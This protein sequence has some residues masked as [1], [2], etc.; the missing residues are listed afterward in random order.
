MVN[1]V[2][3]LDCRINADT[4]T[5]MFFSWTGPFSELEG[6][7][8]AY[9]D[10]EQLGLPFWFFKL[11]P[12]HKACIANKALGDSMRWTAMVRWFLTIDVSLP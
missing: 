10:G 6:G 4:L 2:K 1:H 5:L 7:T 8:P 9:L 11:V 3:L 12:L